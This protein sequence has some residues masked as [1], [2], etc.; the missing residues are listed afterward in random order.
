MVQSDRLELNQDMADQN[1]TDVPLVVHPVIPPHILLLNDAR[2]PLMGSPRNIN[3]VLPHSS[4][5]RASSSVG[6]HFPLQAGRA[7][8]PKQHHRSTRP[9]SFLFPEEGRS[10]PRRRVIH[11]A[12]GLF[13]TVSSA[14]T[15]VA[16]VSLHNPLRV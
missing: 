5:V 4:F 7:G 8:A 16:V 3:S 14:W 15:V 6:I 2:M 10:C 11:A 1:T 9:L 13:S 12:L